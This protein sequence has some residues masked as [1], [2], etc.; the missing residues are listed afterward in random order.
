MPQDAVGQRCSLTDLRATASH[1]LCHLSG[2][3]PPAPSC[4]LWLPQQFSHTFAKS[5]LNILQEGH[6]QCLEAVRLEVKQVS[7]FLSRAHGTKQA[8]DTCC[9]KSGAGL[10]H[11]DRSWHLLLD[12][13]IRPLCASYLA[14]PQL[15]HPPISDH[16]NAEGVPGAPGAA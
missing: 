10:L 2:L 6:S 12:S 9:S 13:S 7:A 14:P 15:S 1:S 11:T 5:K 4:V 8:M 3:R 16:P